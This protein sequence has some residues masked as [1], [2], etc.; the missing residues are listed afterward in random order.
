MLTCFAFDPGRA[1]EEGVNRLDNFS[2]L[3]FREGKRSELAFSTI[4]RY[5]DSMRIDEGM[6][7]PLL[8]LFLMERANLEFE[9]LERQG[10][11][12]YLIPMKPFG[13]DAKW[14]DG[15]LQRCGL[16]ARLFRRLA[17]DHCR[18]IF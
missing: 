13:S 8:V 3:F 2:S 15:G 12:G 4:K 9:V 18:L 6:L 5:L 14:A 7:R 16:Y 17:G 10:Q 1:E 11:R